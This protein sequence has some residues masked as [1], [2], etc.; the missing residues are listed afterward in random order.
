M[1]LH[2]FWGQNEGSHLTAAVSAVLLFGCCQQSS[3]LHTG[4]L[5]S[6]RTDLPQKEMP[7]QGCCKA[8]FSS[9]PLPGMLASHDGE[10]PAV[11]QT[12]PRRRD[13]A[14]H[15]PPCVSDGMHN[16][17]EENMGSIKLFLPE[18]RSLERA[19][20]R[21]RLSSTCSSYH[22]LELP[23]WCFF[24]GPCRDPTRLIAS[25]T[26]EIPLGMIY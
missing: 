13:P 19:G 15:P 22:L 14:L 26:S 11:Q 2:H 1:P 9:H 25:W 24:S 23:R 12:C 21:V 18:F 5:P 6:A 4:S 10:T 17:Q 16:R 20:P 3:G 8:P 7:L